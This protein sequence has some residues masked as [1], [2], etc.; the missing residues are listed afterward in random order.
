MTK[1][2]TEE[3]GTYCLHSTVRLCVIWIKMQHV[4]M[5]KMDRICPE[6]ILLFGSSLEKLPWD[7][8]RP[9][10]SSCNVSLFSEITS[11][12]TDR[13][14]P[15]Q[16]TIDSADE[17]TGLRFNI[18]FTCLSKIRKILQRKVPA[19]WLRHVVWQ[20]LGK[21]MVGNNRQATFLGHGVVVL[22]DSHIVCVLN[23]NK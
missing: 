20:R 15:A 21:L 13:K 9:D 11:W 23:N 18:P 12:A 19:Y 4:G 22:G 14:P 1:I 6:I 17:Q 8:S 7:Q 16:R 2:K 5:N 3:V 10:G